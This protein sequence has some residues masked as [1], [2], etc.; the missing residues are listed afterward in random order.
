V[1]RDGP[2]A[3]EES[4]RDAEIEYDR[5]G[6]NALLEPRGVRVDVCD[7]DGVAAECGK[8]VSQLGGSRA[9]GLGDRGL[10]ALEA[11]DSGALLCF[12]RHGVVLCRRADY[13]GVV[14][15]IMRR[16]NTRGVCATIRRVIV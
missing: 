14:L 1:R 13:V 10:G 16:A 9:E 2:C 11:F 7:V 6:E 15:S 12:G 4:E 8:E 3:Q 5:Y